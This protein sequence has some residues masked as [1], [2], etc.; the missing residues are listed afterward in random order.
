MG[1]GQRRRQ[2]QRRFQEGELIRTLGYPKFKLS[3][4]QQQ[5][6]LADYLPYCVSVRI[7]LPP[8]EVPACRDI[9]DL[10]FLHLAVA[11]RADALITGDQD[12]LL[13]ADSFRCPII[14][15]EQ[16]LTQLAIKNSGV[17]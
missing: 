2:H 4:A 5:E 3:P 15:A 1:M 10:P 12:L 7:P 6:L 14:T 17:L 11:G 9:C 13:L 8:P 16:L